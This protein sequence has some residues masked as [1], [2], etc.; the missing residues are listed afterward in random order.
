MVSDEAYARVAG[1][2]G[3]AVS[4]LGLALLSAFMFAGYRARPEVFEDSLVRRM[5]EA[6]GAEAEKVLIAFPNQMYARADE[7]TDGLSGIVVNIGPGQPAGFI[8]PVEWLGIPPEATTL[9]ASIQAA[10]TGEPKFYWGFS[11]GNTLE[12]MRTGRGAV[13]NICIPNHG[14][15][16]IFTTVPSFK[17]KE[18]F[19]LRW[20]ESDHF[21]ILI[22]ADKPTQLI[23]TK[24]TFLGHVR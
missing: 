17:P 15:P 21:F 1:R 14:D 9:G 12:E 19:P 23:L 20:D 22:E 11:T 5:T 6:E 2:A 16:Y 8:V 24:I 7:E 13:E 10:Y 4:A 3:W 18:N